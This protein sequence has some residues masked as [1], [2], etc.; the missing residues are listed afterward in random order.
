[1]LLNA[2]K[3][4]R[5]LADLGRFYHL[6]VKPVG[7]PAPIA[8]DGSPRYPLEPIFMPAEPVSAEILDLTHCGNILTRRA[9]PDA[10]RAAMAC[11]PG[12]R[13]AGDKPHVARAGRAPRGRMATS[14]R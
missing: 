7:L 8:G 9:A 10:H 12:A 14:A 1:M 6:A 13:N 5:T 2:E 3:T 11:R 4:S